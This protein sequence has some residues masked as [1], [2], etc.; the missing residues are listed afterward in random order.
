[1][2]CIMSAP[3]RLYCAPENEE[4]WV[5]AALDALVLNGILYRVCSE[6]GQW[7]KEWRLSPEAYEWVDSADVYTDIAR[8]NRRENR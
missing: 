1:M 2:T 7:L 4:E 3:E 6:S 8:V 5:R